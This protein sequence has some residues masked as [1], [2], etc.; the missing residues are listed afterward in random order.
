MHD[1]IEDA[2]K[3]LSSIAIGNKKTPISSDALRKFVE[4]E[5][6]K[7]VTLKHYAIWDLFRT[8]QLTK[9]TLVL[10]FN[11]FVYSMTFYGLSLNVKQLPGD[12]YVNFALLSALE[13]V[14]LVSVLITGNRADAVDM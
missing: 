1:R 2:E 3:V 11:W 5:K 7:A 13:L 8:P 9:Y 10:M 4:E 6:A 14:A 12:V